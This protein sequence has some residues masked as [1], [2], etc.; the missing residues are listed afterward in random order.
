MRLYNFQFNR[1]KLA[2]VLAALGY[3]DRVTEKPSSAPHS[4]VSNSLTPIE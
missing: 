1:A 3:L 4:Y 2:T